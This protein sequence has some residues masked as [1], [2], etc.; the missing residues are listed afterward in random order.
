[1]KE[2]VQEYVSSSDIGQ[3]CK[4]ENVAIPGLLQPLEVPSQAWTH[5]SMDFVEVC[6]NS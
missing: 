6:Q 1:M 4:P 2:E 5:I 3:R